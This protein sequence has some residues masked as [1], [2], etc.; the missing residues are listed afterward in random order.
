[1]DTD[2]SMI[3]T[4]VKDRQDAAAMAGHLIGEHLAACVQ[5]IEIRSHYRWQG[6]VRTDPE[7]LLLIKTAGDRVE[8][9]VAAIRNRHGYE[10]PEILVT[11]FTGGLDAYLDWVNRQ[12]RPGA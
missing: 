12:T 1:M 11:R 5:E 8:D 2:A 7:I 6:A 4:T 9:A 3:M 10:V